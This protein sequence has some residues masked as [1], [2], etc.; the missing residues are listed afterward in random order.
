[1][2]DT[3]EFTKMHACGNDY[4]YINCF[5][6]VIPDPAPLAVALSDRHTGIGADGLVLI[7]HSDVADAKMR[8]FNRDGSESA[9]C[10]NAVRCV[11]KYLHDHGMTRKN[12]LSVE[13]RSGV[14]LLAIGAAVNSRRLA[15]RGLPS[16]IV[17]ADMDAPRLHPSEIP[18][19]LDGENVVARPVALGGKTYGITCVSMGNPH[20]VV[21]VGDVGALDLQTTGPVFENA[22][23]F[24]DR[25]NAEFVEVAGRARL[26]VR[27]WERGSGETRACGTGACAAVVAAVLNGLCDMN[28]EVVVSLPGGELLVNY[29]GSTVLMSGVCVTVFEGRLKGLPVGCV[30]T[31]PSSAL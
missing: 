21:F 20:A 7:E 18:V 26:E 19:G 24:P 29:T 13:T 11:G 9:M 14:R 4:V 15:R 6:R 3:L 23:I 1:M 12:I 30:T 16:L 25:V 5:N 2:P 27:V 28:T 10:G 17:T 22:G 8:M 31:P